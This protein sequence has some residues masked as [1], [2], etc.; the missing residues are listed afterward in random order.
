MTYE[1]ENA[2]VR[3]HREEPVERLALQLAGRKD[4]DAAYTLRQIEGW[5]RLRTKVPTWAAVEQLHYPPRLSLEQCSGERAARYKAEV[6]ARLLPE[7]GAMAD[8]TGGLG[9]DFS[10]VARRFRRATYVERSAEL[11]DL[12]R[13]NFPL[14]GLGGA[15]VVEGDGV[16]YLR[17]MERV[18]LLFLDPARRD[19]AG[20]KTVRIEDC[21]PDVA[22]L[23]PLLLDRAA[24]VMLKLSPML[25]LGGALR[26]L[27]H[28]AEAHVVAVG[29]E[30]KDLLLI[31]RAGA[32]DPCIVVRE[33]E[34]EF[35]FTPAEEAAAVALPAAE[36]ETFLYEPGAAVM[37]A[38]AFRLMAA[39]FGLKKLHANSHLY[40]GPEAVEG[41]PGRR[42]RVERTSGFGKREL[43]AFLADTPQANLTVRNFPATV[44]DLRRRLHLRD[45]GD[46]YLFATTLSDG[47]HCLVRCCKA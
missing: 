34:A 7:G 33:D 18:D 27:R 38:G 30:C 2:F 47:R 40:T 39:R 36:P 46:V 24:V 1:T 10:F 35:R 31:L 20:R 3:L 12:A 29:G 32:A 28:V 9:V 6:V 5:Q 11:C 4:F 42:F 37:K 23:L 14:L 45:G 26:T 15:E 16:D 22:A 41:F 8:L 43:K 17:R 13:R 21:E 25:D 44:A 19:A